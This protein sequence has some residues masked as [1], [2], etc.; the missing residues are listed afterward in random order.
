MFHGFEQV[1]VN[2]LE[3]AAAALRRLLAIEQSNIW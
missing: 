3:A 2:D 1:A